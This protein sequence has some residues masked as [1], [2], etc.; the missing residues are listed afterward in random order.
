MNI[1]NTTTTTQFFIL[2]CICSS[3]SAILGG[4]TFVFTRSLINNFDPLFISYFRYGLTGLIFLSIFFLGFY[5][6]KFKKID[7]LLLSIIGIFMF[8]LFPIFMALGL[9]I[10]TSSRAGLLYASMPINTII[11]ACLFRVESFTFHKLIAVIIA[12]IGVFF[13]LSEFIDPSAP[14]PLKGD[15]LMSL[16]VLSASVFTV[17]SG[18][19][20]KKYG[21]INVLI[22][23]ILIGSLSTFFISML[24]GKHIPDISNFSNT[25]I[26][27]FILLIV[28]GGVLMMF[29]WGKALQMI[30]PTQ[31]SITLGFNPISATILGNIFLNE[32]ISQRIFIAIGMI[33]LAIIISN[34][35]I[36]N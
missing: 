4:S 35:K 24:Y 36:K 6:V 11:I 22:F 13:C 20:L 29:L 8:T 10:T 21:N 19:F 28:P 34:K 2:G 16:G 5:R 15:I 7:L 30:T 14:K 27:Y 33:I 31:A 17:F 32:V 1:F 26:I 9:E 18:N 23:T 12:F 25:A 3:L